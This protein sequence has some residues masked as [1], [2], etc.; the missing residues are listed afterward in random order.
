[1]RLLC[2]VAAVGFGR[3]LKLRHPN[4]VV[5]ADPVSTSAEFCCGSFAISQL[6]IPTPRGYDPRHNRSD[7][8]ESSN[9]C[10]HTRGQRLIPLGVHLGDIGPLVAQQGLCSFQSVVFADPRGIAVSQLVR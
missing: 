4:P 2:D 9:L 3:R 8:A 1:M 7:P 5:V 6:P 10:G